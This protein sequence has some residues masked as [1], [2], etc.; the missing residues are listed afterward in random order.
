MCAHLDVREMSLAAR[1][2]AGLRTVLLGNHK[3]I[4]SIGLEKVTKII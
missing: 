2:A 3:T 1:A 4:E